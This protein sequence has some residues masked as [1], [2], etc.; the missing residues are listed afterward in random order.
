MVIKLPSILDLE[1]AK[2]AKQV[3]RQKT[4]QNIPMLD[5]E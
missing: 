3:D 5:T 4:P 2:L 1:Q